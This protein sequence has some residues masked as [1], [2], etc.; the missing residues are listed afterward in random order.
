MPFGIPKEGF[1]GKI[2]LA[3]QHCHM[4][5]G[6]WFSLLLY[7]LTK[8]EMLLLSGGFA[9]GLVMECIQYFKYIKAS[10]WP[11]TMDDCVRDLIF[12]M[13]GGVIAWV[14]IFSIMPFL[15]T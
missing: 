10:Q 11:R 12:W 13:I 15:A 14:L 3:Y 9:L 2:E 4:W 7:A 1:W 5:Y 8:N 6:F